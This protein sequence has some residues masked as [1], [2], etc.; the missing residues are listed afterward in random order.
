MLAGF[1]CEASSKVHLEER[2]YLTATVAGSFHLFSTAAVGFVLE[3]SQG[4]GIPFLSGAPEAL[5]DIGFDL[6]AT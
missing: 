1:A 2:T 3:R 6:F 4:I 5:C